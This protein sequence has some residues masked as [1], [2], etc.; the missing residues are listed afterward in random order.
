MSISLNE[1]WLYKCQKH[2]EVGK[3]TSITYATDIAFIRLNSV[4]K[5]VIV[6][7]VR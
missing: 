6:E 1:W 3:L 7:K 5:V 4:G 2:A